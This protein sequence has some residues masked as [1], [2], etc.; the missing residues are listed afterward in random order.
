MWLLPTVPPRQGGALEDT[1]HRTCLHVS[2]EHPAD[3]DHQNERRKHQSEG[4]R[5]RAKHGHGTA[6][7][8]ILHRREATIGGRVDTHWAWR[9]LTDGK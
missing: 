2:D 5:Q 1:L 7:A 8:G 9:H 3:Q 4:R 6:I